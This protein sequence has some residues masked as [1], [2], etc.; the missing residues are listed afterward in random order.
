[1]FPSND[2]HTVY[3]GQSASILIVISHW[4]WDLRLMLQMEKSRTSPLTTERVSAT[5]QSATDTFN[6]MRKFPTSMPIWPMRNAHFPCPTEH[7]SKNGVI[8]FFSGTDISTIR[9]QWRKDFSG[10]LFHHDTDRS[11][12]YY[13]SKFDVTWR[14][15]YIYRGCVDIREGIFC[16]SSR[17][18]RSRSVCLLERTDC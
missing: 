7:G 14:S 10:T 6:N 2:F 8:S 11:P 18:R 12:D 1:M 9:R 17:R 13:S 3:S 16:H 4:L 15:H 5:Q